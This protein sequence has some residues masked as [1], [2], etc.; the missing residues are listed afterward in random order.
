MGMVENSRAAGP[1]KTLPCLPSH[2]IGQW[3][4]RARSSDCVKR[5]ACS[6]CR[7]HWCRWLR[8]IFF[9]Q[10]RWRGWGGG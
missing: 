1:V 10:R 9:C 6:D 4:H 5:I 7:P 2:P 8:I 3:R